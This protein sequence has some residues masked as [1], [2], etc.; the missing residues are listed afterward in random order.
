MVCPIHARTNGN[1]SITGSGRPSLNAGMNVTSAHTTTPV[2]P[3]TAV[4]ALTFV[5]TGALTAH[6]P[7]RER[8]VIHVSPVFH[9]RVG[10]WER[11]AM[12]TVVRF[13]GTSDNR[14]AQP[15][16]LPSL[17]IRCHRQRGQAPPDLTRSGQF[18]LLTHQHDG[19]EN[20]RSGQQQEHCADQ[21]PP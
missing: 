20:N 7:L 19:Q 4:P 5:S 6:L 14:H 11:T 13:T 18:P 21:N 3:P 10:W 17:R 9:C 2:R 12:L 16:G 15:G 1:A 8:D